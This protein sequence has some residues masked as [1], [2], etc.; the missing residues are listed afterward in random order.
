MIRA[1]QA[2][3]ARL[4]PLVMGIASLLAC[5]PEGDLAK[6]EV[7][8]PTPS[9]RAGETAVVQFL[10]EPDTLDPYMSPMTVTS[11]LATLFYSGL[12]IPDDHGNWAPDL[13]ETVPTPANGGVR[14]DRRGM[15]VTYRLRP[16][17]R[18]QDGRALT[19]ADVAA[20]F[21]LMI[22]PRFPSISTAGYD[23]I[24]SV[25]ARDPRTVVV[26]YK[27]PY[28]PY[29]ELFPFIL[30]A[31]V[32]ASDAAPARANWN[33]APM[34]SG[35]Y[36]FARW[37]SG[38]RLLAV[39]NSTYFRGAPAIR[40]LEVRFV[41]QDITAFN[42][43]RAGDLDLLQGA[44]PA[45]YDYFQRETPHLV[46]LSATP[47]WEHLLLNLEHGVLADVR[48]RRA[49]AHL[50]DRQVLNSTAYG[51]VCLPAWS[52]VPTSSWAFNPSVENRYPP[53]VS[54]AAALLD[55]A[56]WRRGSDG[57]RRR[58]G[59]ILSLGLLTT[60]DKPSRSLAAQLWRRQWKDAGIL[61]TIEKLPA[62]MIFGSGDSGGRL[63][64]GRFDLAL[65]ASTSRSDPDTSFRW[66]SDQ[67]PPAG[68]NRSRYR[69][70]RV[71]RLLAD[72]QH[73]VDLAARRRIYYALADQIGIDLPAIPLL[74]W[75]G[76]D[77]TSERLHGFRPNPSMRGNLWNVWEWKLER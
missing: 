19:S 16:G 47:T 63:A 3:M 70:P 46:H 66:R 55:E 7:P 28:A 38:D 11:S 13:A 53:S 26:H 52:E 22:D 30:P 9:V 14:L 51:G 77:A 61:L 10:Q 18:W 1:G 42:L 72:G 69:S 54:K 41:S 32:V 71:D 8:A 67:F 65:I 15:H 49:L 48:V 73:T 31:H 45:Q 75:V 58:A 33:R 50:I 5:Q 39:A 64:T 24:A 6:R 29:L 60:S 68:Q 36:R 43:W 17:L 27:A 56:G 21:R 62:S 37:I 57:M 34:G 4:C 44:S 2:A 76:I 25:D 59:K 20:T 40:R 74:Y 35:P 23:Q 12:V